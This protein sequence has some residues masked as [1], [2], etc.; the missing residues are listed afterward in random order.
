MK[1]SLLLAALLFATP[2]FAADL[3][4]EM[5][6]DAAGS[7][8]AAL[9]GRF[10]GSKILGQQK[11]EFD[12]LKIA[13]GQEKDRK[14][15]ASVSPQGRVT[16]TLYVAPDERATLEVTKLYEDSLRAQGYEIVFKCSK[17]E[18]GDYF[19]D[20]MYGDK[21]RK[22]FNA[23]Y[24]QKP[25]ARAS[26]V[27]GALEYVKDIRYFAA[28]KATD[29]GDSW[30]SVYAAVQTGGSNGDVSSALTGST[31]ALVEIVEPKASDAK[32]V[33]LQAD[34]IKKSMDANG[35]AAFYGVYFDF[36]KTTIKPESEPQLAEM[37]KFLQGAPD[38]KIYIVGHT[39]N[40]GSL[41]YNQ[42]LSEGRAQS[43][44]AALAA[45][46]IDKSRM[47]AKGV[48]SLAPVASNATEEGRA[49]NRRVEMVEQ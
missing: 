3:K 4:G 44:V 32:L 34:D 11:K 28:K 13:T 36:D 46:G 43:V 47:A 9:I 10:E 45:K 41:E 35:R 33:T 30:V 37:A 40:K 38:L 26:L 49:K 2:A 18:C 25:A 8:D 22:I 6:K 31:Q 7:A 42:K 39:D 27:D 29:A 48:A 15:S 14:A 5:G 21:E 23:A 16:R 20:L 19:K 12:E 17:E 24:G 1:P